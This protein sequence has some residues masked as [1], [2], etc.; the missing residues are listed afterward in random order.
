M[1]KTGTNVAR[2]SSFKD[3]GL[4]FFQEY[5]PLTFQEL[6]IFFNRYANNYKVQRDRTESG[7]INISL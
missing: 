2:Q 3:L 6:M 5:T 4:H 7:S 1:E